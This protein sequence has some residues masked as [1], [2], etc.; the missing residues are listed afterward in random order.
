LEEIYQESTGR[1][2]SSE[3]EVDAF[4]EFVDKFLEAV[5]REKDTVK[6]YTYERLKYGRKRQQMR[7][8]GRRSIGHRQTGH[9]V[10]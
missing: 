2:P 10:K 3:A 1:T 8:G 9:S 6:D 7:S 4:R 5:G